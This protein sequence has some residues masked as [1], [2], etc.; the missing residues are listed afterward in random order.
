MSPIYLDVSAAVHRRAGLGRYADSLARALIAARPDAFALFYNRERNAGLPAGFPSVPTR[1]VALGYKPWRSLVLLAQMLRLSLNRVVPDVRLFHAMEHLLLPLR[2]VPTVLTVH[3]LIFRY[4]PEHHKAMNRAY[5]SLAMP[6]FCRRASHIITVSNA[7]K[8]DLI[9]AY[10]VP[11]NKI[12]VIYEAADPRFGPQPAELVE[13]VRVRYGLPSAFV[14]YVGTIEPRKNLVRLLD[15]WQALYQKQEAPP[16][17]L[18]GRRGW[19]ADDFFAA[20]ERCPVRDGVVLTGYVEDDDLPALY[21][22]ATLFVWPSLYEGF[23]LPPLEAMASGVAVACANTSSLPEVV[24]D[25]ALL[26]D[27]HSP[28]ALESALRSLCSDADLRAEFRY[29]GFKRAQEFS[30]ERAARETLALY[31]TLIST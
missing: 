31:D 17:V 8:Q 27:P 16:L 11:S 1:T 3:D 29:R 22:A 14:L 19:L 26:F 12:S 5:L 13:A 24:G 20:L 30:W 25:A 4:L 15:A 21:A 28:E 6:L 2:D 23:G 10:Q 18:I 7:S 9:A